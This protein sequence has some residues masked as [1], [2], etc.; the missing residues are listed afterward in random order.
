MLLFPLRLLSTFTR[1]LDLLFTRLPAFS[2]LVVTSRLPLGLDI[3]DVRPLEALSLAPVALRSE[4]DGRV[5][6]ADL[7]DWPVEGLVVFRLGAF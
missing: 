7:L 2:R 3:S 1:L 6:L 5:G 4:V